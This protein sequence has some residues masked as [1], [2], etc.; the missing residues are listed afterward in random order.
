VSPTKALEVIET[1]INTVVQ[2]GFTVFGNLA[3]GYPHG[4]P[5]NKPGM[6][7]EPVEMTKLRGHG[8]AAVEAIDAGRIG[9]ARAHA[10]IVANPGANSAVLDER[11]PSPDPK[12]D[13]EQGPPVGMNYT[14]EHCHH[15][16]SVRVV[17]S[18]GCSVCLDCG[19]STGCG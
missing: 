17:P 19:E 11:P 1:A 9:E 16:G 10:M 5:E 3:I 7:I 13:P 6:F 12:H 15:C 8:L 18:G 14:G 4:Q 2:S